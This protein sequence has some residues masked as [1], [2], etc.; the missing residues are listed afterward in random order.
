MRRIRAIGWLWLIVLTVSG[1]ARAQVSTEGLDSSVLSEVR[2]V[3]RLPKGRYVECQVW[4]AD[5]FSHL[6]GRAVADPDT[7][8]GKAW[9]A[10]VDRDGVG[11]LLYGPYAPLEAGTYVALYRIKMVGGPGDESIGSIDACIGGGVQMLSV[12]D[13]PST[14]LVSGRYAQ[15]PI[16]FRHPGGKI[17]CRLGWAGTTSLRVD[18]VTL[19]RFEGGDLPAS[20]IPMVA[21]PVSPGTLKDLS[22][23]MESRPFADIFPKS[24]KPASKL[25]VC[26]LTKLGPDWRMMAVT[27][28]GIVNRKQPRVYCLTNST[29]AQWLDWMK[30]RKWVTSTVPVTPKD[31]LTMFGKQLKG[32]VVID[33]AL[34]ATKN[35]A[36]MVAGV[37]D[38]VVVSP[39]LLKEISLPVVADLRGRWKKNSE[40]Y[41]WAFETLWPKMNH[42]VA[43][44]LWPGSVGLRDY[45]VQH[46]IFVFWLPGRI[47]GAKP[48]ADPDAELRVCEEIL[49]AMPVNCPIMGYSWAGVDIGMGEGGG[50]G[51]MA[52]YGKY[53]VG[54]VDCSNISVHSGIQV[55]P[56]HQRRLPVPNLQK[57]KVYVAFTMSDGDNVPVITVGNWPQLWK[58]RTRGQFPIG[59][60]ISPSSCMLVPDV[61]DYYY[62][63]ATPNDS[64]LAAVSG[65]GYTYSNVYG[66]RYKDP[67]AVFDG[68]LAQS[69]QYMRRM[70][71]DIVC[72]SG[73]GPAQLRRYAERIPCVKSIFADYGRSVS[74]YADAVHSTAR[75]VPVLHAVTSWD[76]NG[77]GKAQVDVMVDQ[78]KSMTP[79][80]DRPVFLHA[81]VCNWFWTLPMLKEV[82][83]RLGPDYVFVSP[84]QMG[85]TYKQ[86]AEDQQIMARVPS[87]VSTI[88]GRPLTVRFTVQNVTS[89][90]MSIRIVSPGGISDGKFAWSGKSLQPG[91]EE[92]VTLT[93]RA[94]GDEARIDVTGAF[95]TRHHAVEVRSIPAHEV[96]GDVPTV[97]GL[98]FVKEYRASY[99]PHNAGRA[100]KEAGCWEAVK[101]VDKPGHMAFGPYSSL[102]PGKYLV[103]FR[104]KRTGEGDGPLCTLDTC[105]AGAP[106][107]TA[108]RVLNVNELPVGEYRSVAMVFD[109]PGGSYESRI[110]WHGNASLA[111]DRIMLWKVSP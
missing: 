94:S 108:M 61:M 27:L 62:S 95:G 21:Q 64:F 26:D 97:A 81:F 5:K 37:E 9:E 105:V 59:W 110:A 71:L 29:D 52:E 75:N 96:I 4:T 67:T 91:D 104:M 42:H 20:T 99:L 19:Y 51:L 28:Q 31:L 46:R 48:Y 60:T 1:C 106:T 56:L 58:D 93:G 7:A 6:T 15:V 73:V 109:H 34:P 78:L 18:R 72:P 63:T 86:W 17:E 92:L 10:D 38:A 8:T 66:K 53:L 39:R 103:L 100:S 24:S 33:P 80:K 84:D 85:A 25:L 49:A 107:S 2:S 14:D 77:S 16:A 55:K 57:G 83:K 36:T 90:P 54:S 98:D 45:L 76:P 87:S 82:T 89:K 102:D 23:V 50:V 43:A 32:A 69:D 79:P 74:T 40:A 12:Q 70:D 47:D 65:V 88:E 68:F 11:E 35:I 30:K 3:D 41:R 22:P 101:G 111:A 13:L 44:C